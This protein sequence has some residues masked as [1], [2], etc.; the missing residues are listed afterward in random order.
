MKTL[1]SLT[2][3]GFVASVGIAMTAPASATTECPPGTYL[4]G[5]A[6]VTNSTVD[7]RNGELARVNWEK[8]KRAAEA[9]AQRLSG[10]SELSDAIKTGSSE[11]VRALL[12]KYGAPTYLKV[13][14]FKRLPL[15][16]APAGQRRV[17]GTISI[18]GTYPPAGVEAMVNTG[19]N[20]SF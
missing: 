20:L 8:E 11:A 17:N 18:K 9:A 2:L 5:A 10:S 1:S 7:P 4:M 13:L 16:P 12:I 19:D 6:C 15:D 14:P 3:L